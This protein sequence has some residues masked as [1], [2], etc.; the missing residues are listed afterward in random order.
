M[1][2][3]PHALAKCSNGCC[4]CLHAPLLLTYRAPYIKGY[5]NHI[6]NH[7]PA[8]AQDLKAKLTSRSELPTAT[9]ARDKAAQG[10][11]TSWHLRSPIEGTRH[12]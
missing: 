11:A 5:R 3:R 7:G 4:M 8:N 12:F 6:Q 10:V 9:K 2:E 1:E